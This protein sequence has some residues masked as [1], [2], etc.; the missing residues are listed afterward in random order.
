MKLTTNFSGIE[1]DLSFIF[2]I[3]NARGQ[4]INIFRINLYIYCTK[5]SMRDVCYYS[6]KTNKYPWNR[7][8][9][10]KEIYPID[11]EKNRQFY[12]H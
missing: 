6:D 12:C 7:Q 10:S 2:K 5:I 4:G 9:F 1:G 8:V 11:S 3:C